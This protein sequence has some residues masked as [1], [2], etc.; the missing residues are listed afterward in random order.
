MTTLI[1]WV[2]RLAVSLVTL[3]ILLVVVAVLL[4]DV[5]AKSFTEKSLRDSTGMD[6]KIEKME[7]GLATPTV[8][9]EGLKLYNTTNFGPDTFLELPE[10][11]VEY[12]PGEIFQGK[13][14][15]KTVRLSI[16]ELNIVKDKNGRTNL[17]MMQKAA[18][19]KET[20]PAQKKTGGPGVEFGGIDTFYLSVGQ[21]KI[22]DLANPAN[23]QVINVALKDEVGRNLKTEAE[24][25]GWFGGV[26]F[27]LYIQEMSKNPESPGLRS[28]LDR[29]TKPKRNK[30]K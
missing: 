1:R 21:L 22:T 16:A 28:L 20:E 29:G 4:K 26:V 12:V 18:K 13:L 10:L 3:V 23:N 30:T 17:E 14:H 15:L 5:I 25:A 9:L 8:S 2:F 19:D 27:K 24:V 11:R 6:A 7:V